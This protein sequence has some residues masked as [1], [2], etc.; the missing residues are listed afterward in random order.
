MNK[1]HIEKLLLAYQ[2]EYPAALQYRALMLQFLEEQ[3]NFYS[4]TNFAGHITVSAWLL[5]PDQQQAILV[6]HRKLDRWLQI[7]GHI[8]EEDTDIFATAVREIKEESGIA[9]ITLLTPNIFDLD[10]HTIPAN[11]QEPSHL[12]YD[13][14]LLYKLNNLYA[15]DFSNTE[16]KG[17]RFFRLGDLV[18]HWHNAPSIHRMAEKAYLLAL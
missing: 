14:R 15:L 11:K 10:I 9:Q 8:E 2:T 7:G 6:H 18:K 13:I 3:E 16:I 5:S 17:I 4:R 1:Q 12:H